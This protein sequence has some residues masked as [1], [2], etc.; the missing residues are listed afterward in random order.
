MLQDKL[1]VYVARIATMLQE[2]LHVYVAR[3]AAMLQDKLHVYVARIAAML[4]DKLHVFCCLTYRTF[5]LSKKGKKNCDRQI[6]KPGTLR[7]ST[8]TKMPC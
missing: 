6:N 3:I 4:Q 5:T 1:H 7:K 2:K 8:L